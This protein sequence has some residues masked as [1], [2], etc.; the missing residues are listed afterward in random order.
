MTARHAVVAVADELRAQLG[1]RDSSIIIRR[2]T[3]E[4]WSNWSIRYQDREAVYLPRI[5][6]WAALV[7][8]I[9]VGQVAD[10]VGYLL[11]QV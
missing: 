1:S 7:N 4:A 3:A 9:T 8:G 6:A 2:W 5:D 11:G 10:P